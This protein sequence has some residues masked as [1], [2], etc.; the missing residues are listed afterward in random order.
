LLKVALLEDRGL[1]PPTLTRET[2]SH[3]PGR[4]KMTVP[5]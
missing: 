1:R 5:P 2:V 4:R 3:D